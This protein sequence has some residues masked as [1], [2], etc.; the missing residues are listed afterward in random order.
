MVFNFRSR[1]TGAGFKKKKFRIG[2]KTSIGTT[3][4][5]ENPFKMAMPHGSGVILFFDSLIL[6]SS[7]NHYYDQ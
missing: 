1:Q 4:T 7:S 2:I 3:T 6:D 5:S